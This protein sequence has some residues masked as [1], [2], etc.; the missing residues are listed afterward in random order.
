MWSNVSHLATQVALCIDARTSTS[1]N[2]VDIAHRTIVFSY[3]EQL[4]LKEE[5]Q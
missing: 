3:S 5:K 4:G 1:S 2:L